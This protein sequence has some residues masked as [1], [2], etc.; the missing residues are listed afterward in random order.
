MPNYYRNCAIRKGFLSTRAQ[1]SMRAESWLLHQA[2]DVE[3]RNKW[4]KTWTNKWKQNTLQFFHASLA[5]TPL[6]LLTRIRL[7]FNWSTIALQ[8]CISF[9]VTGKWI[10]DYKRMV[11][12]V[13]N[14]GS[15]WSYRNAEKKISIPPHPGNNFI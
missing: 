15:R 4:L 2:I 5:M 13:E 10:S 1:S 7:F 3:W 11:H 12:S 6:S 9:R 14:L 8:C